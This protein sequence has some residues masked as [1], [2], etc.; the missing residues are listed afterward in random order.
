MYKNSIQHTDHCP[1]S[2]LIKNGGRVLWA[3]C[4][5]I[6][7]PLDNLFEMQAK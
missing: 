6:N 1:P 5:T 2:Q 3:H 4:Q 7:V